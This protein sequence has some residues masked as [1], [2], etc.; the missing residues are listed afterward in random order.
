MRYPIDVTGRGLAVAALL[1]GFGA[2]FWR[3]LLGVWGYLGLAGLLVVVTA[4][5]LTRTRLWRNLPVMRLPKTLLLYVLVLL[6]AIPFTQRPGEDAL[7]VFAQLAGLVVGLFLAAGLTWP[8]LLSAL[9][10]AFIFLIA[11]SLLFELVVAVFVRQPVHPLVPREGEPVWTYGALFREGHIQGLVGSSPA[12][13]F[14]ALLLVITVGVQWAQSLRPTA[15]AVIWLVLGAATIALTRDLPVLT[16]T[17]VCAL[18]LG[19]MV[20]ARRVGPVTR[21]VLLVVMGLVKLGVVIAL[22]WSAQSVGAWADV[23]QHAGIVGVLLL[24]A[25]ITG[26]FYR[27]WWFA[28]DRPLDAR[29]AP[30][31]YVP[32]TLYPALVSTAL[33][34]VSVWNDVMIVTGGW[35]LLIALAV[36]SKLDNHRVGLDL[37]VPHPAV[38]TAQPVG[39]AR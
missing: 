21:V 26:L 22:A 9:T 24:A 8:V 2:G 17:A 34:T 35:M 5:H 39:A 14:I 25:L 28:V 12:L 32:L 27:L 15:S 18:M 10:R 13:G 16:A 33:V 29:G 23:Q 36:H 1:V 37:G 31:E 30:G 38:S 11:F 19:V 6:V 20:L 7:V 3:D 4:V